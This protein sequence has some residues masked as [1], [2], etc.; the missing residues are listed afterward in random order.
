MS[1]RANKSKG[2]AGEDLA[3]ACLKAKGYRILDRNWRANTG[4]LDIVAADGPYL[5]FAEVKARLSDDYGYPAEAVT[6]EKRRAVNKAAAEYIKR[7]M[8]F[9]VPVRFDVVEVYL[10]TGHVNHIENASD[11]YLRY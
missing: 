5:V 3:A 7:F 1:R 4:E 8:L 10:D 11:S 2:A 6:Y 9:D